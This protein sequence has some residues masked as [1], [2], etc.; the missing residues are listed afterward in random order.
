MK[1]NLI[2]GALALMMTMPSF[3]Q[4]T[5]VYTCGASDGVATREQWMGGSSTGVNS[6]G[7]SL[8]G[9][10]WYMGGADRL[11]SYP[12]MQFSLAE[13]KNIED[14]ADLTAT[15]G[16]YV[17]KGSNLNNSYVRFYDSNGNGSITYAQGTGG[18]KVG[19]N[20][21]SAGWQS[22]DV[23][24]QFK[25]ALSKG[26]DWITFNLAMPTYDMDVAVVSSEGATG[27]YEGLAPQIAVVIPEP[28]TLSILGLGAM[29]LL[30]RK[31]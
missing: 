20:L 19:N 7:E 6:G 8:A 4:A 17:I 26:Y 11:F 29:A 16:F 15:L 31:K 13:F 25:T 3:L 23:T 18:S 27:N 10:Y 1:K 5:V 24:D 30:R 28:A 14:T 22:I 12:V 2:W 21:T 9:Y